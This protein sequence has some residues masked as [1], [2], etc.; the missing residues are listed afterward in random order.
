MKDSLTAE[1][2]PLE[3]PKLPD[4][5]LVSVLIANYNY[6]KYIGKALE[7]MLCQ[8]YPHFEV[9]ICDDGSTDDSREIIEQY[10]SRDSRIKF[11]FKENG[12]VASALNT[13]YLQS[14]GQ[15]ICLL[16]ADDTYLPEKLQRVVKAFTT[17]P[18][19]GFVAHRVFRIDA[20]GRRQ[21]VLPL[22]ALVP[23]GWHGPMLLQNGGILPDMPSCSGLSF[24]REVAQRIFPLPED[25]RR[26]ADEIFM[27][28]APLMTQVIGMDQALSEVR[29][30]GSNTTITSKITPEIIDRELKMWEKQWQLQRQYLLTIDS[31]L[32]R[33][34]A[35]LETNPSVLLIRY[36]QAR[37]QGDRN[38]ALLYQSLVKYDGLGQHSRTRIRRWFWKNSIF[39]PQPIFILALD[40]FMGQNLIKRV[41]GKLTR[42]G[43]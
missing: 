20:K 6:A 30:H 40:L 26:N 29:C 39:L 31:E 36:I 16:D 4:N 7:N 14:S 38:F 42:I 41:I 10:A 22:F 25:F 32:A 11:V 33:D 1:L 15:I 37:L 27:R 19:V 35:S 17:N 2:K 24:R 12:G 5:P 18:E 23:S 43:S 8:T 28:L 21:G 9:I 34:F 3:L 13:A